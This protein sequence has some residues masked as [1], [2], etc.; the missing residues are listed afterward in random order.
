MVL[1]LGS[2]AW[3]FP[4]FSRPRNPS[5]TED[6]NVN[7]DGDEIWGDDGL[8]TVGAKSL[9]LPTNKDSYTV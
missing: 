9:S 6:S 4:S 1:L 7:I 2:P 3:R 8:G 5:R